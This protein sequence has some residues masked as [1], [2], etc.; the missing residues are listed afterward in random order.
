MNTKRTKEEII[1]WLKQSI[2]KK[3]RAVAEA[4]LRMNEEA[5]NRICDKLKA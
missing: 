3:Q 2:L 1:N 4:Q 5:I